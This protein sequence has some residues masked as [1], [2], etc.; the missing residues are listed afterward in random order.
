MA[1]TYTQVHLH[2]VFAVQNRLSLINKSW[3]NRLYQYIIG[4]IQNHGHKVL[5][6]GGMPDHIHIL[7]GLRPTQSLSALMQNIKRDSS[8]WINENHFI[9]GKFSWQEGYGAFSY[10]K[11]QI[12]QVVN[13]IENQEKHHSKQS[14]LDEYTKILNDFGIEYDE[15][16]IF[17]AVE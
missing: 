6:I 17:K 9:T 1:N 13:Y 14:F 3:Q 8:Q 4:I 11:S 15:K 2:I 12:S 7:L 10:S 16:Y 5:S